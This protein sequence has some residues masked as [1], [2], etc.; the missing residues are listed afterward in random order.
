MNVRTYV[1]IRIL[2]NGNDTEKKI[3]V[4][5]KSYRRYNILNMYIKID[6]RIKQ[7]A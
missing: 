7:L 1:F 4:Q 5:T 6:T 3:E 2:P